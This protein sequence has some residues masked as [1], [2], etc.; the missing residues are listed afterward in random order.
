MKMNKIDLFIAMFLLSSSGLQA[1]IWESMR[2]VWS[3]INKNTVAMYKRQP[4]LTTA[5]AATALASGL[6]FLL[7]RATRQ[8]QIASHE[9]M[10]EVAQMNISPDTE[11]QSPYAHLTIAQKK[12][13]CLFPYRFN[14]QVSIDTLADLPGVLQEELGNDHDWNHTA[15]M[16]RYEGTLVH[17]TY[18]LSNGKS[19]ELLSY[20]GEDVNPEI[21]QVLR[22]EHKVPDGV[23]LPFYIFTKYGYCDQKQ[24]KSDQ[25]CITYKAMPVYRENQEDIE[26]GI[27]ELTTNRAFV[28]VYSRNHTL[29]STEKQMIQQ[30]GIKADENNWYNNFSGQMLDSSAQDKYD[31]FV[32]VD[33][34]QDHITQFL[35]MSK[36]HQVSALGIFYNQPAPS[37]TIG[38]VRDEIQA[39]DPAM[40]CYAAG[41]SD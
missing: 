10:G 6:G 26:P 16:F 8:V 38:S 3:K 29:T 37:V 20:E 12:E 35:K 22:Q 19:M 7:W 11:P 21:F 17:N 39:L 14:R 33:N 18:N 4:V 31:M 13:L 15:V 23:T 36:S 25:D 32:L 1:G 5:I 41:I 24:Q 34:N 2:D 28:G 27:A 9:P 30:L 40:P